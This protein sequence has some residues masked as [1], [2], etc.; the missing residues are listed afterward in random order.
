MDKNKL[1]FYASFVAIACGI[2]IIGLRFVTPEV[3]TSNIVMGLV[4][5]TIG[6][7]GLRRFRRS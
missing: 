4:F 3:S 5:I 2:F 1:S 6:L 7:I